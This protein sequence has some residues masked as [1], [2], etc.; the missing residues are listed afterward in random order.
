MSCAFLLLGTFFLSAS[1]S[2]SNWLQWGGPSRDFSLAQNSLATSWDENQPRVVWRRQLGGGH[3]AIL[4]E[5]GVL[6]TMHG[7]ARRTRVVAIDAAQGKTLWHFDSGNRYQSHMAQYDGPHSTPLIAGHRLFTVSIDAQVH[8][9]D[10]G[11]GRLLWQRDLVREHGV[12]LPQSGYA[13]SPVAWRDL[14]LLP[15]LGGSAAGAMALDQRDGS[16]AWGEQSF[17]SSHA[18]PTLISL[19]GTP[20]AIF[21]GMEWLYSLAPDTGSLIWRKKLRS[22][23]ADNISFTP[24]WDEEGGQLLV[25]H[26]YDNSGAQA[27]RIEESG[28]GFGVEK[29]WHNLRLRVEHGNGVLIGRIFIASSGSSPGFLVGLDADDGSLL[30]RVRLPKATF[31]SA[32]N[33]LLILDEEGTLHLARPDRDGPHIQSNFKVLQ[34]N[35]WTAPTLVGKSLYLRDRFDIVRLDLP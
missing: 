18:S 9:F 32:G 25:S 3:S 10:K 16:T 21:H 17:N 8:A 26:R 34:Y 29:A 30:W 24:V 5:D 33:Q 6:Y 13:A 12:D 22:G 20:Q 2:D 4:A 15:G 27:L 7:G 11:S 1:P 19:G 14:I 28:D 35:A 31:V 23:A